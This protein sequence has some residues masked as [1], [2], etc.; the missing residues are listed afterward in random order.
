MGFSRWLETILISYVTVI[1]DH[2]AVQYRRRSK[3][4][5]DIAMGDTSDPGMA[6]VRRAVQVA[7]VNDHSVVAVFLSVWRA[8]MVLPAS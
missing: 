5:S 7:A 8:A 6:V 1:F 4:L 2:G 3:F